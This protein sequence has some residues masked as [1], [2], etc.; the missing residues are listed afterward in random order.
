MSKAIAA[1]AAAV[2]HHARV[3][4]RYAMQYDSSI[5]GQPQRK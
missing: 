5:L 2:P 1:A 4:A 3:R